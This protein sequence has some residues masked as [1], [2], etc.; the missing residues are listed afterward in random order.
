MLQHKIIEI[1]DSDYTSPMILVEV[2]GRDSR[3]CIDSRKLNKLTKTQFSPLPNI[4]QRVETSRRKIYNPFGFNKGI[5]ANT[6]N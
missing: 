6:I 3:P 5:L 4:E 2:A 1:R